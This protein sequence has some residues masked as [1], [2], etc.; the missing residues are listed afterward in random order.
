[1]ALDFSMISHIITF[2]SF[3]W[4]DVALNSV[5]LR[6]NDQM[7]FFFFTIL[8]IVKYPNIP[9][10]IYMFWALEYIP[11][12]MMYFIHNMKYTS[13]A[14][15]LTLCMWV[16]LSIPQPYLNCF[17]CSLLHNPQRMPSVLCSCMDAVWRCD[18]SGWVS[19]FWKL[20]GWF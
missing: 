15:F 5:Q 4:T 17:V 14:A 3:I 18:W 7:I 1:M 12:Y 9:S 20:W 13:K 19:D 2:L 16:L 11:I 8:A 6:A 10:C